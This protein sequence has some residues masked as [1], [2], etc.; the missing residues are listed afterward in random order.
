MTATNQELLHAS[1]CTLIGKTPGTYEGDWHA[2]WDAVGIPTG[3]YNQRMM[4]WINGSLGASLTNLPEAM[5]RYA[6]ALGATDWR[7][8]TSI[9]D[10]EANSYFTRAGALTAVYRAALNQFIMAAKAI[11]GVASIA[12][13]FDGLWVL[14]NGTSTAA[15]QNIAKNDHHCTQV[16]TG[17]F[18]AGQGNAGNGADGYLS[19]DY[20]PAIDGIALTQNDHHVSVYIRNAR[21]DTGILAQISSRSTSGT[22]RSI[23]IIAWNGTTSSIMRNSDNTG[24]FANGASSTAGFWL[25][26]RVASNAR[27]ASRNGTNINSSAA[28]SDTIPSAVM[29]IGARNTDGTPTLFSTDQIAFASVGKSFTPT[30]N[31]L[32]FA[33]VEA[34]MDA[35]GAGIV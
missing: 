4:A 26:R 34:Y 8:L 16:G 13:Q 35:V 2:L 28:T 29:F 32:F 23:E 24:S 12:T 7:N 14:A 6:A 15:Y 11:S 27:H 3:P 17:T 33:A 10:S 30:Q 20:N 25:T 19:T 21:S 5:N 9:I 1:V 18:T 31:P 22:T